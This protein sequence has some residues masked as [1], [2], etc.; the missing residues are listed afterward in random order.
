[1]LLHGKEVNRKSA[2][3]LIGKL[4]ALAGVKPDSVRFY[5]RS[6]LLPKPMRLASGYRA[7]DSDALRRLRFIKQA[8]SLGFSLD[9]IK[10]ILSLRG[11][12]AETCRCVI[13]IAEATLSETEERLRELQAFRDRLKQAVADWKRSTA[14]RRKC[15]AEFCDLIERSAGQVVTTAKELS[16]RRTCPDCRTSA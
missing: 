4:A 2:P 14:R 8:Q 5:E 11:Q 1:M 7:Y 6:G 15:H 16:T 10:R 3:L 12:G 9:E 13:A